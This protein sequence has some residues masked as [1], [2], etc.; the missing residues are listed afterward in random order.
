MTDGLKAVLQKPQ[1]LIM[2]LIKEKT[3]KRFRCET[4]ND[5]EKKVN[6]IDFPAELV[7][8]EPKLN[9]MSMSLVCLI[10]IKILTLITSLIFK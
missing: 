7:S 1:E 9:L 10:L 4:F 5:I 8:F 6:S 3:K 2:F